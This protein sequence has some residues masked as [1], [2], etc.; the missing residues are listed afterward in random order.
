M[1]K[2]LTSKKAKEILHDKEVHGHPLTDKQRKFFGAIA[3]G[4]KPYK[5]EDGIVQYARGNKISDQENLTNFYKHLFSNI[6]KKSK[7][8]SRNVTFL[9][10]AL[11]SAKTVF[12]HPGEAIRAL[13][14]KKEELPNYLSNPYGVDI[15][16]NRKQYIDNQGRTVTTTKRWMPRYYVPGESSFQP[17]QQYQTVI[18][19]ISSYFD[20]P[21]FQE[22]V[23]P[24][25]FLQQYTTKDKTKY[26]FTYPTFKKGNVQETI[27]FPNQQTLDEFYN[28]Y[29]VPVSMEK[30]SDYGSATGYLRE[31]KRGGEIN[32]YVDGGGIEGTMGGLT[33]Q[34]FNF[35]PAWGGAWQN[36]GWMDKYENG[37]LIDTA[38]NGKVKDKDAKWIEDA[39]TKHQKCGIGIEDP[40]CKTEPTLQFPGM[41]RYENMSNPT[42]LWN[43]PEGRKEQKAFM[44]N[45]DARQQILSQQYPN[46]TKEALITALRDSART[47]QL[48]NNPGYTKLFDEQGKLKDST[49]RVEPFIKYWKGAYPEKTKITVPDMLQYLGQNI[50]NYENLINSG[51]RRFEDGGIL[52]PPMA[53]AN[54]TVPMYAM[55]G[56]LPGMAGFTYARVSGA[57]PSEGPY[58]KKTM[59]SAQNGQEMK[60]F[61]NGLDWTPRNISENGSVIPI[62]QDGINQF[63][64][65]LNPYDKYAFEKLSEE[66][67]VKDIKVVDKPIHP[68]FLSNREATGTQKGNRM[69]LYKGQN[70]EDLMTT[71]LAE[72]AHVAQRQKMS[73]LGFPLK[74][75]T[76]D[77][78]S[79]ITGKSPYEKPGTIEYEAHQVIE[80][81]LE[82]KYGRYID[83]AIRQIQRHGERKQYQAPATEMQYQSG[84]NIPTAQDGKSLLPGY[85]QAYLAGTQGDITSSGL[86]ASKLAE[87]KRIEE[88][89]KRVAEENRRKEAIRNQPTIGPAYIPK[90]KEE[91]EQRKQYRYKTNMNFVSQNPDEWRFNYETGDIARKE[92]ASGSGWGRVD[93]PELVQTA[94]LATPSGSNIGAGRIGAETFVNL[95]PVT[96]PI[97]AAGRF[98][99]QAIGENP[100]GFGHGTLSNILGGLGVAGDIA[101]LGS[102]KL[103]PGSSGIS[104]AITSTGEYLTQGPLR[105]VYK[106]NPWAFKPNPEAYYRGIG[107]TGLD[108]A[109]ATGKFRPRN[110]EVV[111]YATGDKGFPTA[112]LY[113]KNSY[114]AEVPKEAF[115]EPVDFPFGSTVATTEQEIPI[116]A[117]R[118]L[119]PDWLR[120]Y[121]PVNVPSDV[122]STIVDKMKN[123]PEGVSK[124]E[125]KNIIDQNLAWVNSDEYAAR[126]MATTGET[127]EQIAKSIKDWTKKFQNTEFKFG[128][129]E[130][131]GTKGSYKGSPGL[132][133]KR[134]ITTKTGLSKENFLNTLDH[135][136]KHALS[137]ASKKEELYRNYPT[138]SVEGTPPITPPPSTFKEKF[139]DLFITKKEQFT[140][141]Q[142]FAGYLANPAEQQVRALRLSEKVKQDLNIPTSQKQI[143]ETQFNKWIDEHLIPKEKEYRE[144]GFTD[145]IN[146]LARKKSDVNRGD[147]LNWMNKAWIGVPA[148]G[149][150]AAALESQ[151][152]AP[153]R[154][155][156]KGGVVKDDMGY[157]NPENWGKV[158]EIDSNDITMQGVNQPLIG[159]SDEGDVQYM[160]P[161]KDYKFKGKK[162]KEY[163]VGKEGVSVNKADEYP[164]HKLDDL[165]NFTNYNKPKAKTGGWL[166]KY[167]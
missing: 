160:E 7:G 44:S 105:N 20:F 121:K 57:A 98:T 97:M 64:E 165:L 162:V 100:Y 116:S 29:V 112:K 62:A 13:F 157:W 146:L 86:S 28:R 34:G 151:K 70:E 92:D 24:A 75:L 167:N 60:Y 126:R 39:A 21:T 81:Q 52:Q 83:D 19:P 14:T 96:A 63:K 56:S 74:Y 72:L 114:I 128:K 2:K 124:S 82:E 48:L 118:I 143:T 158:V 133:E 115:T 18:N 123:I 77:I 49:V 109:L 76:K 41:P 46:L 102:Y 10:R 140:P 84:G 80:P 85:A 43:W 12:Q 153:K 1:A 47:N 61:Q 142:E 110:H 108:D 107:E 152:E 101:G 42:N 149:A 164:L 4:A 31:Q 6:S 94:A 33:D 8:P 147:I 154:G 134:L 58:A 65:L 125:I 155:F 17:E 23:S 26:S 90:T 129:E 132:F 136:I 35:N 91:E 122:S 11:G 117:G 87:Q 30:G 32:K 73:P 150:A 9:D 59:P 66:Y 88:E 71:Y 166:D 5:A 159:V 95:T 27:Y 15:F 38:Q 22:D 89:N 25:N 79:F 93:V 135:E 54:Q 51:Y 139:K 161:G 36:G 156:K 138:I 53:G 78:P 3:G 131:E 148:V 104:K 127:K 111:Y 145:V 55:G 106:I 16:S 163:P 50:G 99:Q 144:K 119:K 103:L 37:G 40:T 45:I 120:G 67:P 141:E 69:K 113:S 130:L 137:P 68:F